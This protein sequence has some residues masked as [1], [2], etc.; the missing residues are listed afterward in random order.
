MCSCDAGYVLNSN[1]RSCDGKF[2]YIVI[3]AHYKHTGHIMQCVYT[4][5]C[6][7]SQMLMN[8]HHLHVDKYVQTLL[9]V[10]SVP[11]VMGMNWIVMEELVTVCITKVFSSNKNWHLYPKSNLLNL[12]F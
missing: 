6:M 7:Y 1:E 4:C 2:N 8:V 12:N 5:T 3:V 9:G 11:V 10:I